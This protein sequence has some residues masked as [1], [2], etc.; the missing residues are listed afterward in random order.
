MFKGLH[1]TLQ[2]AKP[3]EALAKHPDATPIQGAE[4]LLTSE[5][6]QIHIRNIKSLLNLP[7]KLYDSLYHKVIKQFAEFTQNLPETQ[8]GLFGH[9]GG[10]LDHGLER[11]SRALS[12]CL[13]HFFPHEKSFQTASPQEA[14]WVYAVFTAALLLDIGKIAVKFD[15]ELC[16]KDGSAVK[17]WL[18]YTGPLTKQGKFYRFSFVK[19]NLDNL[20]R[21]ITGLLARQ[22][23]DQLSEED[24]VTNNNNVVN[25]FNWIASN[26]DVLETW[27][28]ILQGEK[29]LPMTSFMSV[30]PLAEAQIIDHYFATHPASS[31]HAI[32]SLFDPKNNDEALKATTELGEE[33]L[34]WIREKLATDQISINKE[35]SN[36]HVVE[37]GVLLDPK[38]FERFLQDSGKTYPSNV[39]PGS[40]EQQFRQ[41]LEAFFDSPALIQQRHLLI[42][43]IASQQLHRFVLV[44]NLS[45]LFVAGYQAGF[46]QQVAANP[47]Q[48][49]ILPQQPQRMEQTTS[50][51]LTFNV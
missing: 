3:T 5:K 9:E 39:T 35:E 45:L 49:P 32:N 2:K 6:R 13:N 14:L 31:P 33:F 43:G 42:K 27:L 11:A 21:L 8:H 37:E 15:I 7:P 44:A 47:H 36:V 34:R 50:P 17:P 19:R 46:S 10:F 41:L 26:T 4:A 1:S 23:L 16:N 51:H 18:P 12:L 20:K 38:L 29:R 24:S 48:N 40:V 25:G 30:I 22:V 28:I